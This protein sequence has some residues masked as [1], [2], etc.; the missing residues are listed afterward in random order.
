[1]SDPALPETF[2]IDSAVGEIDEDFEGRLADSVEVFGGDVV[3]PDGGEGRS[4][5]GDVSPHASRQMR[6]RLDEG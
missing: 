3:E 6:R 4:P 1:M 5:I 2:Q